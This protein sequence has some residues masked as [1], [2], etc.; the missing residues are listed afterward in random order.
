MV[1]FFK[2]SSL[3]YSQI[4]THFSAIDIGHAVCI[5]TEQLG[6]ME[7]VDQDDDRIWYE[8]FIREDYYNRY[9]LARV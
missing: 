7:P 4:A 1:E 5:G 9:Q 2:V 6:Y 8:Y 3:T